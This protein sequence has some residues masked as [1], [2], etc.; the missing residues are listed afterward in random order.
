MTLV[1]LAPGTLLQQPRR[2]AK[3]DPKRNTLTL[4]FAL[5]DAIRQSISSG[6]VV[7]YTVPANRT[8]RSS[9]ENFTIRLYQD[10]SDLPIGSKAKFGY[11]FVFAAFSQDNWIRNLDLGG[12]LQFI[13][14]E[15]GGRRITM[16]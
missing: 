6:Y 15:S 7:G 16:Q 5:T 3:I 9:V 1:W 12:F 2:V 4:N 8:L 13:H 10:Q 14:V 11:T